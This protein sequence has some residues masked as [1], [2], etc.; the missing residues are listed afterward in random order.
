MCPRRAGHDAGVSVDTIEADWPGESNKWEV[1]FATQDELG[2]LEVPQEVFGVHEA[3]C[4]H[5]TALHTERE[6]LT[7]WAADEF[8]I[9]DYRDEFPSC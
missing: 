3:G 2:I 8:P 9:G 6:G 7:I 5:L 4:N 1:L